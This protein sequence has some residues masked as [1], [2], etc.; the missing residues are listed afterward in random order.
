MSDVSEGTLDRR[1]DHF[2][3]RQIAAQVVETKDR[4]ADF[5]KQR[6]SL[7]RADQDA[8]SAHTAF[9]SSPRANSPCARRKTRVTP[10]L[11][12][13]PP[14]SPTATPPTSP[15]PFFPP[16]PKP[17]PPLKKKLAQAI[18]WAGMASPFGNR[19]SRRS[20]GPEKWITARSRFCSRAIESS[21]SITALLQTSPVIPP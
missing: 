1:E 4:V 3:R 16:G 14:P 9:R 20:S 5:I 17:A 7:I 12:H 2:E 11:T 8:V 10:P 6:L 18:T 21:A 19:S 13:I 15:R